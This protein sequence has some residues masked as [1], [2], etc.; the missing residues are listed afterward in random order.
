MLAPTIEAAE[1]GEAVSEDAGRRE[2]TR[3]RR[4]R[5][6]TVG[7]PLLVLIVALG[8]WELFVRIQQVPP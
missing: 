2:R 3:V 6:L 5:M 4:E 1:L 8:G 7:A